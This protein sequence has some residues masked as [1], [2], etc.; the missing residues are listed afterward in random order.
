MAAFLP[1]VDSNRQ[2][3]IAIV[4]NRFHFMLPHRDSLAEAIGNVGFASAGAAFLSVLQNIAGD[5]LQRAE[6]IGKS[7][8]GNSQVIHVVQLE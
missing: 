6:G 1:D 5:L 8:I 2:A 7:G 3:F 4:F